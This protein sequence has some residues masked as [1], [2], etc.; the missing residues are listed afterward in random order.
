[1]VHELKKLKITDYGY[2]I[3]VSLNHENKKDTLFLI[4]CAYA[5][6]FVERKIVK[7]KA[8]YCTSHV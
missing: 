5:R 4:T 3:I 7:S 1:M 2:Q 6:V 8:P